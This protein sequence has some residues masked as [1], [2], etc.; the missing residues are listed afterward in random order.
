MPAVAP[1]YILPLPRRP[2]HVGEASASRDIRSRPECREA[3]ASSTDSRERV[4]LDLYTILIPARPISA[5]PL[6]AIAYRG[7]IS[8]ATGQFAMDIV[9]LA[10]IT[11]L[12]V[13]ALGLVAG[14]ARLGARP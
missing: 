1:S 10:A 6:R 11:A 5:R 7:G 13:A 14:C 2:G 3:E 9:S 8:T 12:V 4:L